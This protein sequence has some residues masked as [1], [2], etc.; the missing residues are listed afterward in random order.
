VIEFT[1]YFAIMH[2]TVFVNKVGGIYR[3]S[4]KSPK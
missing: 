2:A 4:Q 3:V 1:D